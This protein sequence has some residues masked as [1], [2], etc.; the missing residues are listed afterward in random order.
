MPSPDV[1]ATRLR[2]FRTRELCAPLSVSTSVTSPSGLYERR[3]PE[4]DLILLVPLE[5][6]SPPPG[7]DSEA[8]GQDSGTLADALCTA[9]TRPARGLGRDQALGVALDARPPRLSPPHSQAPRD[10]P[11]VPLRASTRSTLHRRQFELSRPPGH[12][13]HRRRDDER[14]GP[15]IDDVADSGS[16]VVMGRPR[17]GAS[18]RELRVGR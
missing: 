3:V 9:Q 14:P 11:R 15:P 12:P 6:P 2:P 16:V 17:R 13:V 5:R 7:R 8:L 18:E 10:L 4:P 1:V